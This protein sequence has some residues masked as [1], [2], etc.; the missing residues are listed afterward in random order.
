MSEINHGFT[1]WKKRGVRFFTIPSFQRAGSVTCAMASRVGGV[2]PRPYNTLN[3]SQARE[4]NKDNFLKNMQRFGASARFEYKSAIANKY[5]H[6]AS[7]YQA[8]WSDSGSGITQD[9]LPVFCDGLYTDETAL[10]L[11]T[12]HADC[13]PLFFYDPV[14]K[15]AAICH[16]G[17][18]G[19]SLHI[20][21]EA[22]TVLE[23]LGSAAKNI[24]CA[25]GPCISAAH[26]EVQQD[27]S[28]VFE[29]TFGAD[30]L[31]YR[32]SKTYLDLPKACVID[33]LEAGIPSGNITLSDLCTYEHRRL[34]FSH[35]RDNGE[36]GAMAAV[37]QI[38]QQ[39]AN[40]E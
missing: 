31:Q 40:C 12:Y 14:R 19:V 20:I 5:E 8:R 39:G 37:I 13:A 35:R 29:T 22:I 28:G 34:F 7:L 32:G 11:I 17:W 30:V 3:F 4:Q 21:K 10:P 24:L 6:G 9:D 36:T 27:V 26:F 33:M 25:V 2:S 15:A 38:N 18:K 1:L 23:N 16:A